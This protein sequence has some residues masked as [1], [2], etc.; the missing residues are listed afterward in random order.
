MKQNEPK[1]KR[2]NYKKDTTLNYFSKIGEE[3]VN[4]VSSEL[5]GRYKEKAKKSADDLTAA[6]K[7]RQAT[8]RHMNVMLSL[9]HI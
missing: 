1:Y 3:Q 4:E 9:I 2:D 6:G 7:H 8:D 5:L